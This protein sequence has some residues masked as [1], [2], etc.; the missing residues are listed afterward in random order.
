MASIW[1]VRHAPV[2]VSG[3]CYGQCDIPVQ[4]G[5]TEAAR[6]IAAQWEQA[7]YG[8][9][10]EL[11]SSPWARTQ[12]VA[13]ELARL[14]RIPWRADARLSELHF[15]VWEGR[16]YAEIARNDADRWQ[17]WTQNYEIAA[18]PEGE[19]A[20]QLRARVAA[21]LGERRLGTS[22]VLAVTHAGVMR[23]ARAAIERLPYSSV[24]ATAVPYLQLEQLV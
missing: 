1:L 19:S 13:A 5:A 15:G 17:H 10:P 18:P 8:E 20:A 2:T 4:L 24:V 22:N 3:V 23:T 21:W 14:W 12:S 16:Q 11:W 6:S 7:G 9:P